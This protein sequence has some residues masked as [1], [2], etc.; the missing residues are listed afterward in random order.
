M[1]IYIILSALSLMYAGVSFGIDLDRIG[2]RPP[3][4]PVEYDVESSQS[5]SC[6][7]YTQRLSISSEPSDDDISNRIMR[8]LGLMQSAENSAYD[9][10]SK[11]QKQ[12]RPVPTGI[13]TAYYYAGKHQEAFIKVA[14]ECSDFMEQYAR[15]I[16][17]TQDHALPEEYNKQVKDYNK[18]SESYD[19][20]CREYELIFAKTLRYID[21]IDDSID[22]N[23]K[24]VRFNP[25]PET[26]KHN[27]KPIHNPKSIYNPKPIHNPEPE[28]IQPRQVDRDAFS[29]LLERHKDDLKKQVDA[30]IQSC[31]KRAKSS[32]EIESNDG[33]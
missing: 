8:H 13:G 14:K 2:E 4:A 12:S 10:C 17:G 31:I 1:V 5:D 26:R 16:L 9:A 25:I 3:S 27:P 22:K 23:E 21:N 11:I 19:Y 6:S 24:R 15:Q 7:T 28:V 18:L 29:A 30:Y 20:L 33:L 32:F